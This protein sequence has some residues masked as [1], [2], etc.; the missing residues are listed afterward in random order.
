MPCHAR[1]CDVTG[2]PPA[3]RDGALRDAGSRMRCHG[4]TEAGRTT[5]QND[6]AAESGVQHV[7]RPS[8][9]DWD[10]SIG[11]RRTNER[12]AVI[13]DEESVP[14]HPLLVGVMARCV[15]CECM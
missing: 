13:G 10:G 7:S 11:S 12:R 1:R 9:T 3:T 6:Q 5:R 8:T 2:P 15:A 14:Y 4:E